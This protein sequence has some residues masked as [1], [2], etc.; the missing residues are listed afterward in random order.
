MAPR[1]YRT[2]E[3]NVKLKPNRPARGKL[4]T[5]GIGTMGKIYRDPNGNYCPAPYGKE[6]AKRSGSRQ[7]SWTKCTEPGCKCEI[8]YTKTDVCLHC[9]LR[10]ASD[11]YKY[12]IGHMQITKDE[13][14]NFGTFHT[15]Q[16]PRITVNRKISK[17]VADDI[18]M[19]HGILMNGN[20]A[21]SAKQAIE[22]GLDMWVSSAPCD[23]AGHLGLRALNGECYFCEAERNKPKPRQAA[24]AGGERW[25][26]PT[27]PCKRC[28]KI[29]EKSVQNGQCKGCKPESSFEDRRETP[30]SAMMKADPNMVI[31]RKDARTLGFKVYRTGKECNRGHKGFRYVQT[32][33]CI[34][35]LREG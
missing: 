14:E 25:Y 19:T 22:L 32:G 28:G 10:N 30:D 17:E 16:D 18:L 15:V 31:T 29:A 3:E 2:Y 9:S 34:N 35:C 7:Y 13:N 4:N 27:E 23:K 6:A 20:V 12:C 11:F 24:I 26:L 8:R 21:A 33:S 1:Q 5:G